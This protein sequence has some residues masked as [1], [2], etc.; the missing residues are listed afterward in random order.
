VQIFFQKHQNETGALP[1]AAEYGNWLHFSA[2]SSVT[3]KKN[4]SAEIVG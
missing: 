1:D 2:R 3:V 4:C